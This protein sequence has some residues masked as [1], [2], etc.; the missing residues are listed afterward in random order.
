MRRLGASREE[1]ALV[2][3]LLCVVPV[4]LCG[5]ASA[6]SQVEPG[7][8]RRLLAPERRLLQQNDLVGSVQS[9]GKCPDGIDFPYL[10]IGVNALRVRHGAADILEDPVLYEQVQTYMNETNVCASRSQNPPAYANATSGIVGVGYEAGGNPLARGWRC[11]QAF[12]YWFGVADQFDYGGSSPAATNGVLSNLEGESPRSLGFVAM[13]SNSTVAFGCALAECSDTLHNVIYCFF[14]DDTGELAAVL[15]EALSASGEDALSDEDNEDLLKAADSVVAANV[16]APVAEC[17]MPYTTRPGDD[18]DSLAQEYNITTAEL[19]CF[20]RQIGPMMQLGLGQVPIA[21]PCPGQVVPATCSEY[22]YLTGTVPTWFTQTPS[23]GFGAAGAPFGLTGDDV[24]CYNPLYNIT[25][26]NC[27]APVFQ[28]MASIFVVPGKSTIEGRNCTTEAS[29]QQGVY[30]CPDASETIDIFNDFRKANELPGIEWDPDL[31][32]QAKEFLNRT[33]DV[34]DNP[35]ASQLTAS[36][37]LMLVQNSGLAHPK[38]LPA[39]LF[40]WSYLAN[41]QEYLSTFDLPTGYNP[42]SNDPMTDKLIYVY[43]NEE[44]KAMGCAWSLCGPYYITIFCLWDKSM[45][46]IRSSVRRRLAQAL[47]APYSLPDGAQADDYVRAPGAGAFAPGRYPYSVYGGQDWAG[48]SQ[49]AAAGASRRRRAL[50]EDN[51]LINKTVGGVQ[52]RLPKDD[53]PT[54]VVPMEGETFEE[55]AARVNSTVPQLV[56]YHAQMRITDNDFRTWWL[57]GAPVAVPCPGAV[58]EDVTCDDLSAM[59]GACGANYTAGPADTYAGIAARF[60]NGSALTG[61]ELCCYNQGMGAVING[62]CSIKVAQ[63][64]QV[65]C[66]NAIEDA[67]CSQQAVDDAL[68]R[69]DVEGADEGD[70]SNGLALGLALGIGIPVLLFFAALAAYLV[71]KRRRGPPRKPVHVKSTGASGAALAGLDGS[72]YDWDVDSARDFANSIVVQGTQTT[73]AHM[74]V[75]AKFFR[76]QDAYLH[77]RS[78]YKSKASPE[79]MPEWYEGDD[80]SVK[81]GRLPYLVL[82]RGDTTLREWICK[83]GKVAA[84]EGG[85]RGKAHVKAILA[86]TAEALRA[87]HAKGTVHGDIKPD[88]VLFFAR[89]HRWKLIDF[90]AWASIGDSRVPPYTLRYAAPEVVATALAGTPAPARSLSD[91]WSFGMVA[92]EAIMGEHMLQEF[93]DEEVQLMLLGQRPLPYE[94]D[95]NMWMAVKEEP[96]RRLLNALLQ[97]QPNFRWEASRVLENAYFR[98]GE[99]TVMKYRKFQAINERQSLLLNK[100]ELATPQARAMDQP[101]AHGQQPVYPREM[102]VAEVHEAGVSGCALFVSIAFQELTPEDEAMVFGDAPLPVATGSS[103]SRDSLEHAQY[104]GTA[105]AAA[106]RTNGVAAGARNPPEVEPPY[107]DGNEADGAGA[108]VNG[109][110]GRAQDLDVTEEHLCGAWHLLSAPEAPVHARVASGDATTQGSSGLTGA[111][112][113]G[114]PGSLLEQRVMMH[115]G[116]KY[117]IKVHVSMCGGEEEVPV[118]GIEDVFVHITNNTAEASTVTMVPLMPE[119]DPMRV[120]AVGIWDPAKHQC[121]GLLQAGV[122]LD[123]ALTISLNLKTNIHPMV[124]IPRVLLE[125]HPAGAAFTLAAEG[126]REILGWDAVPAWVTDIS[127]G[128]YFF[129]GLSA[130]QMNLPEPYA[131]GA[132][133]EGEEAYAVNVPA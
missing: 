61:D 35:W 99:D 47:P 16:F 7:L 107:G 12:N 62:T 80:G 56:C 29:K 24:C 4:L 108:G 36:D 104:R 118:T 37:G 44:T 60:S 63:R 55:F 79:H 13:V 117:I 125:M 2:Q 21:I 39:P 102:S 115:A 110:V 116:S 52:F 6:G 103:T 105:N 114:V 77:E 124:I 66:S 57:F 91:M 85:T 76:S 92:W 32:A 9:L 112:D 126:R 70:S 23:D 100:L 53:C 50:V 130:A 93:T 97:R 46:D 49:R 120:T 64:V 27:A 95:P 67:G 10:S 88:N 8:A 129:Y 14:Q 83:S 45:S 78:F 51:L 127:R 19:V 73:G 113:G 17:P 101:P 1:T 58:D 90:G 18:P 128:S 20:N 3:A 87:L 123:M 28:G 96:A 119:C 40:F 71:H 132:S 25:G 84:V 65:P 109:G 22:D 48:P 98:E 5:T 111:T 41:A 121:P 89:T 15:E 131:E 86:D 69:G 26:Q 94:A 42:Y 74:P 75:V 68:L 11:I 72:N 106:A 34:C 43:L 54:T 38:C 122:V 82:E 133:Q 81:C 33:T 31:A 30:D 59:L